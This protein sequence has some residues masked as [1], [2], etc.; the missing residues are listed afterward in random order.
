MK[1]GMPNLFSLF[2]LFY[3]FIFS[4]GMHGEER[5]HKNNLKEAYILLPQYCSAENI[6]EFERKIDRAVDESPA[7]AINI[8]ISSSS[9]EVKE[10]I[11]IAEKIAQ[12]RG[13]K[14]VKVRVYIQKLLTGP[15]ALV[16]FAASEIV[17]TSYVTWGRPFPSEEKEGTKEYESRLIAQ[18]IVASLI[19]N[20]VSSQ[21]EVWHTLLNRMT[22]LSG[23]E[24][25]KSAQD[26]SFQLLNQYDVE[27]VAGIRVDKDLSSFDSLLSVYS[28][29]SQSTLQ[30]TSE[31][32][33]GAKFKKIR[34]NSES[35]I[36]RII[37]GPKTGMISQSTWIYVKAA[38]DHFVKIKPA[39]VILELDTPGG[40]VFAAEKISDALKELDIRYGVPIIA[41]IN[42][43]AISAG[44]MLAYS[45]RYI[46]SEKDG[47][48]GAATP[49]I[50][51]EEGPQ[52]TS[53]KMVS[54]LKADFANKAALFGRNQAIAEAMVDP[55]V[56]LVERN[57]EIIKLNSESEIIHERAARSGDIVISAKGKLLTLNG[58]DMERLKVADAVIPLEKNQESFLNDRVGSSFL[59][60]LPEFAPFK[61]V[62][63]ETYE[64]DY[65]TGFISF[66][67]SPVITSALVFI[68]LVSLYLEISSPGITIPGLL[69]L[70]SFF[71]LLVGSYAQES[72]VW[73][74]P[75]VAI[76][77]LLLIA[78]DIFLFPTG[79]IL[80]G[81]GALCIGIG[82]LLMIIPAIDDLFFILFKALAPSGGDAAPPLETQAA[83]RGYYALQVLNFVSIA[84]LGAAFLIY[85]LARFEVYPRLLGRLS[86]VLDTVSPKAPSLLDDGLFGKQLLLP[87][88]VGTVYAPLRPSGKILIDGIVY[89]AISNGEF[90]EAAA[91]VKVVEIRSSVLS[92]EKF[93]P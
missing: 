80:F 17:T 2:L 67:V 92:V 59:Q 15:L 57:G 84:I 23:I 31:D 14:K 82:T 38:I 48:M 45:S 1:K 63:I 61:D 26:A 68:L 81:I 39:C 43:W 5:I 16:P 76:F 93:E 12:L 79:G 22:G 3:F 71:F 72:I 64:M 7:S 91:H 32:D 27:G 11:R 33:T 20:D 51:T 53:E 44:A 18:G 4:S 30:L 66:I 34:L 69:A 88:Q 87:G 29:D 70:I 8:V 37:I 65:K 52:P 58:S 62:A 60:F 10:A 78:A 46:V 36:G 40:E 50:M 24:V 35:K 85:L 77:G 21:R 9:G 55:D 73:F 86:I 74:E 47:A 90:I 49:V 6:S 75:L 19:S 13:Q 42:N 25:G 41:Y 89:D 28:S 83:L 56:I 54:A